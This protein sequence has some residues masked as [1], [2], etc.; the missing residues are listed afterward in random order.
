L[1]KSCQNT[2]LGHGKTPKLTL[3]EYDWPR[4]KRFIGLKTDSRNIKRHLN[5]QNLAKTFAQ[6]MEKH[7]SLLCRNTSGQREK[8]FIGLKTNLGNLKQHLN[9]QKFAKKLSWGMEKHCS[10][11]SRNKSGQEKKRFIV[12]KP[13][14][15]NLNHN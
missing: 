9:W 12:L 11:L 8:R 5:W 1:A 13:N 4:E 10:L 3:P 2:C 6:E 14:S 7:H 15:C